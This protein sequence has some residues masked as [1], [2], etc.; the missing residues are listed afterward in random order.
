MLQG[1]FLNVG[2]VEADWEL[3]VIVAINARKK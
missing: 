3:A 1:V 2:E